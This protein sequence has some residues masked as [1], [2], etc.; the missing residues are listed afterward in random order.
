M[1]LRLMITVI[2]IMWY[3][4]NNRYMAQWI[5]IKSLDTDPYKHGQLTFFITA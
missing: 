3:L 5:R 2:K 4:Q 1:A